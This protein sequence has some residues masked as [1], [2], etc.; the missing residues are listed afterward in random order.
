M[1]KLRIEVATALGGKPREVSSPIHC[2]N[3]GLETG[4][5]FDN[6]LLTTLL[7]T[8]SVLE[9]PG[10]ATPVRPQ[11]KSRR[12]ARGPSARVCPYTGKPRAKRLV[13][14]CVHALVQTWSERT[15]KKDGGGGDDILKTYF[16]RR[17]PLDRR[18]EHNLGSGFCTPHAHAHPPILLRG[19]PKSRKVPSEGPRS[20]QSRTCV[21]SY[22]ELQSKLGIGTLPEGF[23]HPSCC[24]TAVAV[25]SIFREINVS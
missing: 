20:G 2:Q 8:P 10:D 13:R 6:L 19:D 25:Q 11:A 23:Q 14:S 3:K 15:P 17:R 7:S 24:H 22:N 9:R 18:L 1:R 4:A 21:S 5:S 12:S 16:P